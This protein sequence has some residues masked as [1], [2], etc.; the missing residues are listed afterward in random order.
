MFQRARQA[1]PCV[2]FFDEIDSICTNRSE[3]GSDSGSSSRVV[4]QML[5]E[6][7]AFK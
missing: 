6:M 3:M 4:A 7:V 5:T 2:I 1:N